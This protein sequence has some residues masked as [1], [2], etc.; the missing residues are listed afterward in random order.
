[1]RVV[2]WNLSQVG[3]KGEA[4]WNERGRNALDFLM[5]GLHP[6]IALVQEMIVPEEIADGFQ[7]EFTRTDGGGR[8]RVTANGLADSHGYEVL[9]TEAW[10]GKRWGSAILSRVGKPWI[11]WQDRH[12][13]AAVV[14]HCSIP[15]L[16]ASRIASVHARVMEDG[17]IRA[18]RETFGELLP[19]LGDRFI[20]GGDLNTARAAA[21][22]WPSYGH[23]EFWNALD[24]S[25]FRDCYYIL[26]GC[27]RQSFWREW[28]LGKPPTIGNSLMDDHVLVD[29]ETITHVKKCRVW[30]TKQVRELSDHGPVVVDLDLPGED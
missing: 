4:V 24:A 11:V 2:T 21:L 1:M 6:D 13:G 12:R 29:A 22:E 16:G 17:V 15:F 23:R 3:P 9:W 8:G 10:M 7:V 25:V 19:R 26:H 30:D 20:V 14:A 5:R 27:E 18:L 28:L